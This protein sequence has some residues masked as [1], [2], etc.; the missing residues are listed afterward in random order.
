MRA[1]ALIAYV[2]PVRGI[3]SPAGLCWLWVV[4]IS[5]LESFVLSMPLQPLPSPPPLLLLVDL[6]P[7][8]VVIG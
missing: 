1:E 8:L 6:E 4:G 7:R 3:H 2:P 5:C